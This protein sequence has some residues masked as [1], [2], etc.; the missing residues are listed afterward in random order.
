[1]IVH[2]ADAHLG[3]V[4]YS[5]ID[6]ETGQ[7]LRGQDFLAAFGELC[8]HVVETRPDLFLFSG[9]LFDRVNPTNYVRRAVQQR[10]FEISSAH[11]DT[12]IISGNHE[13]PRSRGVSNPLILYR[14]IPHVRIVLSP[15]EGEA[16]GYHVRA[17]PFV[18]SPQGH[19]GMP[20]HRPGTVLM[21]HTA[22]QGARV[23]SERFMS[24]DEM[25]LSP[26]E[27]PPY[28]Y[29]ALG[30]IH[31]HQV[32]DSSPSTLAYPGALER[33][34]FNEVGEEKGFIVYDGDV[35]H[36]PVTTRRMVS[37][38]VVAD[39][40]RG[41]EI[42]DAALDVLGGLDLF[43][44]VVRL[45]IAGLLDDIERRTINFA[46]I[47]AAGSSAAFFTLVDRTLPDTPDTCAPEPL[48]SPVPELERYLRMTGHY[49]ERVMGRGTAIIEGRAD[50]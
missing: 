2:A 36:V 13:T 28:E 50:R 38:V 3:L 8:E 21:M 1:M 32:L 9:D 15:W 31:K 20:P 42:T 6:A 24:F 39:G 11:I 22:I 19:L 33:Y 49:Q 4:R 25:L 14:D 40:L 41:Y 27:I 17:V 43:N 18:P 5:K 16:G 26:V 10:L 48:V 23:G 29:V 37:R 30:H 44:T 46:A 34:D 7:N 12:I 35:E 47:R 45:E